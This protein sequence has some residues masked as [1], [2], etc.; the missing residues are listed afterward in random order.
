MPNLKR[1]E[2]QPQLVTMD[3]LVTF[4]TLVAR[5]NGH[6][7][8]YDDVKHLLPIKDNE[9]LSA[10]TYPNQINDGHIHTSKNDDICVLCGMLKIYGK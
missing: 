1:Y 4:G 2:W 10:G 7:I 3:G 9:T 8:R 6:L 5:E